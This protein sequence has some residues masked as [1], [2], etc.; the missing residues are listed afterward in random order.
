M[1]ELANIRTDSYADLARAMG[2]AA[3]N[4]ATTKK[5]NTLNRLRIWHSPVMGQAEI[6]GK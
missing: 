6:Y 4:V 5:S 1:T 3:E 2:M